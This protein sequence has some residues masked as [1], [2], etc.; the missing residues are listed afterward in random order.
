[1]FWWHG[2][3]R[4]ALEVAHPGVVGVRVRSGKGGKRAWQGWLEK[5]C[6][7]SPQSGGHCRV[8]LQVEEN[9]C[10]HPP[11]AVGSVGLR[12]G[13]FPRGATLG[14][15]EICRKPWHKLCWWQGGGRCVSPHRVVVVSD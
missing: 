8:G 11:C 15:V 13:P 3:R 5:W 9:D 1:M 10:S 12:G 7:G 2:W 6:R 4:T 14:R